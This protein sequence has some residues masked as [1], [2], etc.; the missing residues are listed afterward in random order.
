MLALTREELA[1]TDTADDAIEAIA[2]SRV[3]EI[4]VLGRRGPAQAAFTTPELLELGELAGADVS[5]TRPTE[6]DARAR[7]AEDAAD[8]QRRNVEIVQRVRAAA[9]HG[10]AA[11]RR[12][13]FL[14]LAGR[15]ARRRPRRGDRESARNRLEP[16]PDGALR[17]VPTGETEVLECGLVLRSVGYRGTPLEGV[18]FDERRAVIPTTAAACDAAGAAPGEYCSGW[19]KRGPSGDHRHEQ[20]G[21]QRDRRR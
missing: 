7:I 13:R 15:A 1:P 2:A 20:E 18:P 14:R 17:A 5:S 4:V 10:Q 16:R 9:A 3:T 12:L 11:R 6:L 21:R 19:I 8:V